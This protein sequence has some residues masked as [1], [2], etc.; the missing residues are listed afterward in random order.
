MGKDNA[1]VTPGESLHS[2]QL[3][4]IRAFGMRRM[5]F[6]IIR[7]IHHAAEDCVVV[8]P[9]HVDHAFRTYTRAKMAIKG[10]DT[11]DPSLLQVRAKR[12][13]PRG[14]HCAH[15]LCS[16]CCTEGVQRNRSI[17]PIAFPPM[18]QCFSLRR[19]SLPRFAGNAVVDRVAVFA[20]LILATEGSTD[21]S[22]CACLRK[23]AARIFSTSVQW[24]AGPGA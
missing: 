1:A 23:S 5:M 14:H 24:H 12:S 13:R 7:G 21:T 4:S 20:S 18:L 10:R 9:W 15:R 2:K 17:H 8:I 19:Q 6:A 16:A 22:G 11:A 3:P